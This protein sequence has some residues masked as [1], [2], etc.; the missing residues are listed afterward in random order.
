VD[1]PS[2]LKLRNVPAGVSLALIALITGC[3]GVGTPSFERD[4]STLLTG[5][6][7]SS[8][9]EPA[10]AAG[11]A[12]Q[13][14]VVGAK[15]FLD[16]DRNMLQDEDEPESEPTDSNGRFRLA[17][18]SKITQEQIQGALLVAKASGHPLLPVPLAAPAA[19]FAPTLAAG[20]PRSINS[21]TSL[22][23][24]EMAVDRSAGLKEALERATTGPNALLA[25][26]DHFADIAAV[27]PDNPLRLAARALA[28][29]V[30]SERDKR[31]HMLA[32]TLVKD[33]A[34]EQEADAAA[35]AG[36]APDAITAPT[37]TREPPSAAQVEAKRLELERRPLAIDLVE[38]AGS[39]RTALPALAP[40]IDRIAPPTATN[41]QL[42]DKLEQAEQKIK[43]AIAQAVEAERNRANQGAGQVGAPEIRPDDRPRPDPAESARGIALDRDALRNRDRVTLIVIFK[44]DAGQRASTRRDEVLGHLAR[45]TGAPQ[46]LR[47]LAASATASDTSAVGGPKRVFERALEGFTVT[48]PEAVADRFIERMQAHPRVDRIEID[49]P[50]R[51]RAVTSP[52]SPTASW[53]VDRSDAKGT[54]PRLNNSFG[55]SASGLGVTAYIV[56]TGISGTSGGVFGAGQVLPGYNALANNTDATDCNG[57][58]TH[59]AGTV[60]SPV[61]GIAKEASLVPVRVLDCAGSGSLSS[62]I[63]GL[64]WVLAQVGGDPTK[65]SRSVVNLSLGG[66]LSSTLDQ[67]VARLIQGGITVVV[68][69]GNSA[70]NACNYSP[71]RVPDALTVAA[72]DPSD[73]R[74]SFSNYGSCVDLFAPGASITSASTTGGALTLSGT[75]MAAPHVTGAVA[76]WLQA[77]P[78]STPASVRTALLGAATEGVVGNALGSPNL[79]LFA[80]AQGGS[81]GGGGGT[82][83]TPVKSVA[84]GG[85]AGSSVRVTRNGNWRATVEV[86]VRDSSG[87]AVAGATVT[88]DFRIGG[89][90]LVCTTSST[91]RCTI[92][93]GALSKNARSTTWTVRA[94]AGTG[95]QYAASSNVVSSIVV[96]APK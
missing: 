77:V 75:S 15:V 40:L 53:G 11:A 10:P 45:D 66:G 80:Q 78:N 18:G 8:F 54:E 72:T 28:A 16:L 39:V 84:I 88:G 60:A 86:S 4:E 13:P 47:S 27:P 21:V 17:V 95:M 59:V 38:L 68:A 5:V 24:G 64:D 58:G 81:T 41:E 87:T 33:E 93:S 91:G 14:Y 3:G 61:Y 34:A 70:D 74:A 67:A 43:E 52:Q 32:E 36:A 20:A 55:W 7:V 2:P 35:A 31:L 49:E 62:V 46:E 89:T 79:L 63:A 57:H 50:I 65:A 56:D 12:I 51:V 96:N 30:L 19:G 26:L 48:L 9:G 92:A 85:L 22:L 90:G 1:T 94:I 73:A 71:A 83:P 37:P 69:A 6:V 29:K 25:G 44:P 23:A 76:Q 42:R 82:E